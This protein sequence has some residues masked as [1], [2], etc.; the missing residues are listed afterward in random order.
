MR[1][2]PLQQDDIQDWLN[3]GQD[4]KKDCFHQYYRVEI[5]G[6]IIKE[7][8]HAVKQTKNIANR[9]VYRRKFNQSKKC[10]VNNWTL[11]NYIS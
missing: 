4:N 7:G 1:N 9:V 2:K 6:K 8:R 11:I 5:N 10:W 3:E